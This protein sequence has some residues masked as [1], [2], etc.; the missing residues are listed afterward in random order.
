MGCTFSKK[1]AGI[2]L[3]Y[4]D[5]N[6]DGNVS[7]DEFLVGVRGKPNEQRQAIIDQA[8]NKFNRDDSDDVITASDLKNVYDCSK[9]PKVISGEM[10]QDEVF[11]EFLGCFGDKNHDGKITR[12][13]WNDHYAAVSSSIDNDDHF[14]LMMTNAWK[15]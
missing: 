13:E 15:L 4:L 11:T 14:C 9:H 6:N 1:E 8:F 7:F 2:L 3:D 5:L 12:N 10:T